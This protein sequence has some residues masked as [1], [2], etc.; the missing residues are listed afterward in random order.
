M[1]ESIAESYF[2]SLRTGNFSPV[3]WTADAILHT[4][5]QPALLV[6]RA[7]IEAF[8]QPLAG[9]LGTINLLA[10]YAGA[11]GAWIA[12]AHVGPLLV[13]DKFVV[14]DGQIVEQRNVFDPRPALDAPSPGGMTAAERAHLVTA[15]E[16][17]REALRTAVRNMAPASWTRQPTDG[18]WSAAGCV[19]HLILSEEQLVAM[20]RDRILASVPTPALASET[21]GKD[22]AVI[23]VMRDRSSKSK[24]FDF[25][26]P[27]DRVT[28]PAAALDSFLA[29]RADTLDFV[30]ATPVAVHYHG[31]PLGALGTIS[32]YQWL[33][34]IAE[35]TS[36]HVAQLHEAV[37]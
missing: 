2:D 21:A 30:R 16:T 23:R 3:P 19:E 18:G 4:P 7:A 35:H 32:A 26:E 13:M 11:E 12:E 34:L 20:I 15:L 1:F 9:K 36:R 28:S 37:S 33:L 8:F 29:R 14:R 25:L 10:T 24:T 22:A 31:A 5:L 27:T 6:G 17:S